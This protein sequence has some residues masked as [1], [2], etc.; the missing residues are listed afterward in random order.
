PTLRSPLFPYTTLFRSI[1]GDAHARVAERTQVLGGKEGQAADLTEAAGALV[2]R[3]LRS[4]GLR[5]ILD[6]L[7]PVAPR[8]LHERQHVGHLP[9]RKSTRLNSSHQLI[10]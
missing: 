5:G 1:L 6:D 4:N 2:L 10:S 7:Q 8:A 3:V 9:D